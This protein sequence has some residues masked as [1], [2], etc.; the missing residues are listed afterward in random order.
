MTLSPPRILVVEDE[1][2]VARDISQQL[3][4]LGYE[5]VGHVARGEQVLERV[6][7]LNP[8]LVLM[9][10]Q[11][12]GSMDGIAVAK[13]L[14]VSHPLP[15]VFLTAFAADEFL[16]RAKL[17]EPYGYILKPF[18][19]RELRTVLEMAL[20][21]SKAEDGLRQA[22]LE[23]QLLTRRLMESQE[24]ERRLVAL[25]LHDELG[26][27]L[28]AIKINL[29][30]RERLQDALP[31]DFDAQNIRMVEEAIAQVRSLSLT[32]RPSMLDDLGLEAALRWIAERRSPR[33]GMD[34]RFSSD[35]AARR[36]ASDVEIA[37]FR[38]AQEALTNVQRHAGASQVDVILRGSDDTLS[39]CVHDNGT[40]FDR[41]AMA[42]RARIGNSIGLLGMQERAALIGAA[43]DINTA[44][45]QGCEVCLHFDTHTMKDPA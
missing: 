26:Q 8:D 35:L 43:L 30:V 16:D 17:T 37:F 4:Q 11:L 32:L 21:K 28:T 38:I 20:Y 12:A 5:S 14:R 10:I 45:G 22:A 3:Q 31:P 19:E 23:M 44:P 42:A 39:L 9:D 27:T 18:S 2:I 7:Q 25:E 13:Q 6:K 40:G 29:Q 1:A 15:V 41:P 34:I 33:D 24:A 36:Y